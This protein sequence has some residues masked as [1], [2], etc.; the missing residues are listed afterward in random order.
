MNKGIFLRF[1]NIRIVKRK[2]HY[3]ESPYLKENV[4]I[5]KI[6]I[7]NKVSF[8][9]KCYK[10]FISHKDDDFKIKPIR[11]MLM[12]SGYVKSFDEPKYMSFLIKDDELLK[13]FNK[14]WDKVS[15]SVKKVFNSEPAYNEK[16]LKASPMQSFII[17]EYLKELLSKFVLR[18]IQTRCQRKKYKQIEISSDDSDDK[19]SDKSD[20]SNQ[21]DKKKLPMKNRLNLNIM[22]RLFQG[23][24]NTIDSIFC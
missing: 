1:G 23:A 9:K 21:S 15:S 6:L 8:R 5:C 18:R 4:D 10:C 13:T 11:M 24:I 19:V 12:M 17:V 22:M 3:R 2:F 14:I 7:S 16:F 20:E